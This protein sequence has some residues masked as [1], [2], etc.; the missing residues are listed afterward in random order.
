M[1][2][3]RFRDFILDLLKF[4]SISKKHIEIL[5]RPHCMDEFKKAFT[6][7]SINPIHNYEYYETLGDATTNKI[8]VWY[9]HRRFPQL[10]D[11]PGGGNMG[12]VAVMA[13]LKQ[14]GVSKR[15]YSG[16][17]E[18]LG[19]WE[20]ILATDEAKK[21][22]KSMLED[23]F[24]SFVGCLE[25]LIDKEIQEHCGYAV[26]YNFMKKIM[27]DIDIDISREHLYDEKSKLNEEIMSFGG[28]IKAEFTSR[29]RSK[30]NPEFLS[31]QK[32]IP[33][34]FET[35]LRI[36]DKKGSVLYTS[37][38][39]YGSNKRDSE[40]RAAKNLRES[41]FLQSLRR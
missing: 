23:V 2:N 17:S 37:K 14:E 24:E 26:I 33:F 38:A 20:Y 28:S 7:K 6:H 40:K 8:V 22:R 25:Y 29:D 12:P 30:D 3:E 27:D 5:T 4:C 13:R 10:F 34:R 11:N 35:F 16:F 21:S 9:Y 18:K 1:D 32:N 41:G 36:I 15:T 31:E 39:G 19:F